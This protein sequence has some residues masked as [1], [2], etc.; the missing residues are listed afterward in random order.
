MFG[1]VLMSIPYLTV[2]VTYSRP[3][4]KKSLSTVWCIQLLSSDG[5]LLWLLDV[6]VVMVNVRSVCDSC[7][8]PIIL[9]PCFSGGG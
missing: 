3:K 7:Y 1:V 5:L 6:P 4:K 2:G 8:E 9:L